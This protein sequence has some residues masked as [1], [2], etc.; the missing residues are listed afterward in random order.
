[1]AGRFKMAEKTPLVLIGSI[2]NR[3]FDAT[4]LFDRVLHRG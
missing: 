4:V 3:V 2:E 1:M